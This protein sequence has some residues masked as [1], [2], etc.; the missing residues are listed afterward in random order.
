L[1][2]DADMRT[3]LSY[4]FWPLIVVAGTWGTYLGL[5]AAYPLPIVFLAVNVVMLVFVGVA[6]QV[7]PHRLD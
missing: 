6:E 7:L 3:I 5:G 2:A 1:I 4:T